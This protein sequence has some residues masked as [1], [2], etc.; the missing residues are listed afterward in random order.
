MYCEGIWPPLSANLAASF[1]AG[2][3]GVAREL[4]QY[5]LVVFSSLYPPKGNV[6]NVL[7]ASGDNGLQPLFVVGSEE[8]LRISF[9][10]QGEHSSPVSRFM[11]MIKAIFYFVDQDDGLRTA[12][13]SEHYRNESIYTSRHRIEW[14]LSFLPFN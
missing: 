11:P 3:E 5:A 7:S 4:A 12:R 8:H 6:R 1:D 2:P 9:P 10:P 13:Q 14:Q